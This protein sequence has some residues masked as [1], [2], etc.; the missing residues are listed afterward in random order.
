MC[1]CVYK[2]VCASACVCVNKCVSVSGCV[3]VYVNKYLLVHV[4]YV[5]VGGG[6]GVRTHLFTHLQHAGGGGVRTHLC[7]RE[8]GTDGDSRCKLGALEREKLSNASVC[9]CVRMRACMH[10][11][12]RGANNDSRCKFGELE[13]EEMSNAC[14]H[15]CVC[16]CVYARAHMHLW[17][18]EGQTVT[19][20]WNRVTHSEKDQCFFQVLTEAVK[21][22]PIFSC[23]SH[24]LAV[25]E[26]CIWNILWWLRISRVSR[27]TA[28]MWDLGL[29]ITSRIGFSYSCKS[30]KKR[31]QDHINPSCSCKSQNETWQ[32]YFNTSF[33]WNRKSCETILT[34][35]CHYRND[36]TLWWAVSYFSVAITWGE[37]GSHNSYDKPSWKSKVNWKGIK[38]GAAWV[39]YRFKMSIF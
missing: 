25:S 23:S 15:V 17:E 35:H 4:V 8:R 12:K 6:G 20:E 38:S 1:V 10:L 26:S 9:V 34:L 11:W 39:Q 37:G 5:C 14:V 3:Y 27:N 28:L 29:V 7:E 30:W 19:T 31:V 2:C 13:R 32:K 18:R 36:F 24:F 16:V 21:I 33:S 22:S